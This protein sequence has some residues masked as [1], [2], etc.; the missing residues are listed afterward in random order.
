V[1]PMG[2]PWAETATYHGFSAIMTSLQVDDLI[3]AS[4]TQ[5]DL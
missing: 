2:H 1:T 3:G 5:G 4:A